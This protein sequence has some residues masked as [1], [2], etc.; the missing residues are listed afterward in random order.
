MLNWNLPA[1]P[2]LH[3]NRD[4]YSELPKASCRSPLGRY[5]PSIKPPCRLLRVRQAP[6][7]IGQTPRATGTFSLGGFRGATTRERGNNLACSRVRPEKK[8]AG[9][10]AVACA[11]GVQNGDSESLGSGMSVD[12]AT[13][14]VWRITGNGATH[15]HSIDDVAPRL[16]FLRRLIFVPSSRIPDA[17]GRSRQLPRPNSI[18]RQMSSPQQSTR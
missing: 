6:P 15:S 14:L 4:A 10:Y 7:P 9:R 16:G 17:S 5:L 18:R 2:T 13:S 11:R 8:E 12:R 1:Q 3:T